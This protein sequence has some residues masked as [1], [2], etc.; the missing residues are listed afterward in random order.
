MP[1]GR[2]PFIGAKGKQIPRFA[3]DDRYNQELRM[4]GLYTG[5]TGGKEEFEEGTDTGGPGG[6]VVFGALDTLIEEVA[7]G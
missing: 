4:G 2:L 5:L 3:L 7:A 1:I 6:L